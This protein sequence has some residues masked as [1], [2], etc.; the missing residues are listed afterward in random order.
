MAREKKPNPDKVRRAK[1]QAEQAPVTRPASHVGTAIKRLRVGKGLTLASLAKTSGVSVGMLSQIERDLSNPSLRVLTQIRG[2]LDAPVSALFEE[3]P[4]SPPTPSFVRRS[5]QHPRL[6]LGY[7]TKEL[8]TSGTLHNLQLMILHLPP[9]GSSGI[10]SISYPADKGGLVLEG[11][12]L[13][14]VGEEEALLQLGDSFVFDSS[15]PHSFL[16]PSSRRPSRVL[17]VIGKFPVDR[18]L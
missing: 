14:K 5:A 15:I 13:L 12:F 7:F 10:P 17:W 4:I 11:E 9:K 1:S 16:N 3:S 8:L 2:A 18:H 6:D